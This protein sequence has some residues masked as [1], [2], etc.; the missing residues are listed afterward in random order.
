[1]TS[2]PFT[3]RVAAFTTNGD[4]PPQDV[5]N[6]NNQCGCKIIER[7]P[8]GHGLMIML[9]DE[10]NSITSHDTTNG[11]SSSKKCSCLKLQSQQDSNLTTIHPNIY[12]P[13]PL[14]SYPS[15]LKRYSG[16][17]SGVTVFGGYHPQLGSLVM[18]HGGYKDLIELV[19]LAKIER[20]VVVRGKWK[21]D[22]LVRRRERILLSRDATNESD[23][24]EEDEFDGWLETD[25]EHLVIPPPS[26]SKADIAAASKKFGFSM[27]TTTSNS[28]KSFKNKRPILHKMN[29][30]VRNVFKSQPSFEQQQAKQQQVAQINAQI[31]QIQTAM[32]QIQI[33]IPAFKMIYIS[34]MHL[35]EREGELVNSGKFRAMKRRHAFKSTKH[36][37]VEKRKVEED[38]QKL[39]NM[40]LSKSMRRTSRVITRRTSTLGRKGR[41]IHLFGADHVK[42]SSFDVASNHVDVCFG[43]SYL[44]KRDSGSFFDE[45]E[46]GDDDDDNSDGNVEAKEE[47]LSPPH[48]CRT[49]VDGSDGY[50]TLMA[51][52]NELQEHQKANEWKVTLA[53]QT[54]GTT[55]ENGDINKPKSARTASSLLYEGKL[56]GN[57]L[58]HLIDEEIKM[59]RNMQ[60]LTMP[61]EANVVEQ[62]RN[63][64][65]DILKRQQR[66]KGTVSAEDVSDLMNDFVGKAIHKNFHPDHGR[67]VMLRQ[68]GRD[69]RHDKIHL[70]EEEFVPAMHLENL[71]YNH[72]DNEG[73]FC[74]GEIRK[75]AR[76]TFSM[77]TEDV[78]GPSDAIIE[79]VVNNDN[80]RVSMGTTLS[81]TLHHRRSICDHPIFASGLSQWQSLL[82]LSLSMKH[83]N[84]TNR[85]WTSGLTDGGLHN[86]FLGEDQMWAFDLGEPSLEPI[87]AFLTKFLMSFFHALGMEEDE[88]GDWVVRFEQ[89]GGKLRPTAAT[90]KLFPQIVHSFNIT[91]DRLIKELFGGEE[92]VRTLLL[93]YV[94]TQLISDAAFCIEKWKTKGGGDESR[95][96]HQK[97]LEK[98]LWR[99][100]WDVYASEELRR[101]YLT[102]L[103][104][105]KQRGM[106]DLGSTGNI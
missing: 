49:S 100:L 75:V 96:D 65:D 45:E 10:N 44:H 20:E 52:V 4:A 105:V 12:I 46:S 72:F 16:G 59:I 40:S 18:K 48:T 93:R 23:N 78:P 47:E 56:Q 41:D 66:M 43:G 62:V 2:S 35:R 68:F 88:K 98:W 104:M 24:D 82:E 87:P 73:E 67:F 106:R 64:Y 60:L 84:A 79:D 83:P 95:S 17:G 3:A 32:S 6:Q 8:R 7:I 15:H 89:A 42:L 54:I 70:T 90:K 51:F 71:F 50:S 26:A 85:V 14:T 76:E 61:E 86:L 27:H 21:I 36:I 34:P 77:I 22:C 37:I 39:E 55:F 101:L 13:A 31:D 1:M 58:H 25:H 11:S 38:L 30:T 92:E 80:D 57:V 99:A 33:R 97:N 5:D 91:V 81:K 28:K 102:R 19:S 9:N 53:Q 94:V 74:V 63:E 29:Q 69:L 103:I